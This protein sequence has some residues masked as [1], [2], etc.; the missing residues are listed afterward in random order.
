MHVSMLVRRSTALL[1]V[2]AATSACA[3]GPSAPRTAERPPFDVQS[4]QPLAARSDNGEEHAANGKRESP[5]VE[6]VTTIVVDPNVPRTYA[7]GQNWIYFPARSICDPA[8][9][10]YAITLWD[11]PCTALKKPIAVTVRWSGKGGHAFARFSPELRF[12]PAAERDVS[13]WVILSLHDQ[14]RLHD[15]DDYNI[16][17]NGG[18]SVGWLDEQLLDPTLRPWIDRAANSVSRRI[19]H[20]SG[21]MLAAG[22]TDSR[23]G[24]DFDASY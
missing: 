21:Y 9:S 13:R 4:L 24:G 6:N 17:Y 15:L 10:G 5:D 23:L 11:S 8:T 20:F 2:L 16:L 14:K 7:F 22:F 19:K 12:V 1:V 18:S 3:D